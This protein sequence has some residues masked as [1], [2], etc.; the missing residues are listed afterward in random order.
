M[1]DISSELIEQVSDAITENRP[2]NIIGGNSKAFYGRCTQGDSVS[3][4]PHR[5]IVSYQPSELVITARAGTKISELQ[6]TLAQHHQML[7]GE[8]PAF[9]GKATLG[10]AVATGLSG[11]S[12]PFSGSIRD[13]ILGVRVIN[14]YAEHLRFGGQVMKNVAG[15]DVSRLQAGAFGAFGI[16]TEVSLRVKPIP[17]KTLTMTKSISAQHALSEMRLLSEKG[18]P[19]SGGAWVDGV[20]Y[21]RLS[22]SSP[23][24]DKAHANI[25]G[26]L[27][28]NADLFWRAIRNFRHPFFKDKKRLFR[29]SVAPASP[30]FSDDE[31]TLI[32][33]AGAIRWVHSSSTFSEVSH[34]AE[35]HGGHAMRFQGENPRDECFHP[36]ADASVHAHQALKHA[37]DPNNVF[38]PGRMYS[39]LGSHR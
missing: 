18:L 12:R 35:K 7:V 30:H 23:S 36:L 17:D 5:G 10:G 3:I 13:A 27:L 33:W 34:L 16:L 31:S 39:W 19:L 28:E 21:V 6:A 4:S 24:V 38:N 20:L 22:G 8:P 9:N 2:L 32:D 29:L 14:G 25:G 26:D 11:A 1:S 15:Y 37:F